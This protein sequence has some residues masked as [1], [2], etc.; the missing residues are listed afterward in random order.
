MKDYEEFTIDIAI[1]REKERIKILK[2]LADAECSRNSESERMLNEHEKLLEW[3]KEYRRFEELKEKYREE[4]KKF[5]T[6]ARGRGKID[7]R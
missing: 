3:L 5:L 4:F 1:E 7:K 6:I 2:C